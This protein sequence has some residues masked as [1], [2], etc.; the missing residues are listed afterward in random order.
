MNAFIGRRTCG[1]LG[2]VAAFASAIF[3]SFFLTVGVIVVVVVAE[4]AV[5]GERGTDGGDE[6]TEELEFD[7]VDVLFFFGG[8][9]ADLG[10][11]VAFVAF[12]F[13]GFGV[14]TVFSFS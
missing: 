10:D 8:L 6:Q 7:D 1:V 9:T 12:R 5:E 2:V 13:F 14:V 11:V 4:V 3:F